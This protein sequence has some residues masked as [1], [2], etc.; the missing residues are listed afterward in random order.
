MTK[1]Q[2]QQLII[3][4]WQLD[5][6]VEGGRPV[7]TFKEE[8]WLFEPGDARRNRDGTYSIEEKNEAIYLKGVIEGGVELISITQTRIVWKTELGFDALFRMS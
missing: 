1:E 8:Q 5:N 4:A 7:Y 3:G 6:E 2:A